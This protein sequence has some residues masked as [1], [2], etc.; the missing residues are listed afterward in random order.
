M[1]ASQLVKFKLGIVAAVLMSGFEDFLE[2][3]ERGMLTI[4]QGI[5]P[6]SF[7]LL[8]AT[9][10]TGSRRLFIVQKDVAHEGGG[11]S[12]KALP[13][14]QG[15]APDVKAIILTG[16]DVIR[17][18]EHA[19]TGWHRSQASNRADCWYLSVDGKLI[20]FQVGIYTHD[21]GKSYLVCGEPRWAGELCESEAGLV[22]VP[23]SPKWGSL[24][25]GTS[26]R[27]QIFQHPDFV[28]LLETAVLPQFMGTD[29]DVNPPLE[30][31]GEGFA[32]VDWF[33]QFAGRTGQGIAKL[34][35][36]KPVWVHG[37]DVQGFDPKSTE[38]LLWHGDIVSYTKCE[39]WGNKPGAPPRIV[40]VKLVKRG[41]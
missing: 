24:E 5:Q 22:G 39:A 21:N 26:K 16:L 4:P 8:L 3:D 27:T 23:E 35:N 38:P 28:R 7:D 40:G 6:T 37:V 9:P 20:L 14:F 2:V 41:H 15:F 31:V 17:A 13:E 18:G 36:G 34:H 12:K 19:H 33:I 10:L 1:K 30:K 11:Y 29:T 25:G 32:A